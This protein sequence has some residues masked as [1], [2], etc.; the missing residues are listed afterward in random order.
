MRDSFLAVL[1]FVL[2]FGCAHTT[3]HE[4]ATHPDDAVNALLMK[5]TKPP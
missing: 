5:I 3:Q 4:A 2:T 1:L